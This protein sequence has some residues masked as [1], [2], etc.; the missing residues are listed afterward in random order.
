MQALTCSEA[1][2]LSFHFDNDSEEESGQSD[3]ETD[4]VSFDIDSEGDNSEEESEEEEV[5][6]VI[7]V[8]AEKTSPGWSR[9][10]DFSGSNFT[11]I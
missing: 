5:M 2:R 3:N 6:P 11:A 8:I 7:T 4:F 9:F 1:I 10:T